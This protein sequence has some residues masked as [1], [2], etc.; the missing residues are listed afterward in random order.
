MKLSVNIQL[1]VIEVQR[2]FR[3]EYVCDLIK[4][5][6]LLNAHEDAVFAF[7]LM[8][9]CACFS[10]TWALTQSLFL[11]QSPAGTHTLVTRFVRECYRKKPVLLETTFC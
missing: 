6:Y 10:V 7:S 9:T 2:Y 1:Y 11:P 5:L 8:V 4:Q 3:Q